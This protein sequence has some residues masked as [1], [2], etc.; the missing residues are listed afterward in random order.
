MIQTR[1]LL[2]AEGDLL[3]RRLAQQLSAPLERQER[4]QFYG[5]SLALNMLQALPPTA[6]QIT[7][8]A[9]R[10]LQVA[11]KADERG[12]A[13]L[14]AVTVDGEP[15]QVLAAQDLLEE[16]LFVR[17]Q[18]H[19]VI[20]TELLSALHGSEHAAT[21]ALVRCLKSRPVLQ[22]TQQYLQQLIK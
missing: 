8:R 3:A 20:A 18:L 19:P 13:E 15:V 21:R 11:L 17:G 2:I 6:E 10:P 7:R 4:L 9:G 12:R 5:R 22:A 16:A 1:D 14:W